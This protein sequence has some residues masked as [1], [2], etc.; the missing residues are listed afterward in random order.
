M[1]KWTDKEIK[2]L[3]DNY[4]TITPTNMSKDIGRS[5]GSIRYRIKSLNLIHSFNRK[6]NSFLFELNNKEH[7]YLMGFLWADGYLHDTLNR[8]ELSIVTEDF[9]DINILFDTNYWAIYQRNRKERK[10]QTTVG[11]YREDVCNV[12]RNEY[13]YVEKSY[14]CPNFINKI[15]TE[16]LHY[17]IRGFFDGDGCFY[18]SADNKQKQCYLA[19][20]YDQNW[21]WIEELFNDIGVEYSIKRKVQNE[22]S[23]YSIVYI[24]KKSIST[25]GNYIYKDF[26][27][28]NIGLKRKYN[29]FLNCI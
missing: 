20:S 19:G 26:L 16:F 6:F 9:N 17:F 15:P 11:L 29:K 4:K 3:K 7:I 8:L 24:K 21:D 10:P 13:N 22:K 23:K 2:Y 12:F 27:N 28:D 1:A 25:F 18:V 14:K 5:V